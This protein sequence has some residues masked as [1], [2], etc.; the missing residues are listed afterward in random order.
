MKTTL[1]DGHLQDGHVRDTNSM[2]FGFCRCEKKPAS[3]V[4]S[5]RSLSKFKKGIR[6]F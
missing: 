5:R 1:D 3:Y 6:A 2:D 4:K